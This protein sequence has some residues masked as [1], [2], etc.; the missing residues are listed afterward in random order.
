LRNEAERPIAR[1]AVIGIWAG[2]K[3]FEAMFSVLK[4]D[5]LWKF[6]GGFALGA[7]ALATLHPM[8][9]AQAAT[10]STYSADR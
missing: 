9:S 2:S 10:A 1:R 8:D 3:R 6:V 7:I 4:S 5:F